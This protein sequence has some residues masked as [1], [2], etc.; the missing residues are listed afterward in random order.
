MVP[1]NSAHLSVSPFSLCLYTAIALVMVRC[2]CC[3][4]C[5]L[6]LSAR[7]YVCIYI[8]CMYMHACVVPRAYAAAAARSELDK[9]THSLSI[10]EHTSPLLDSMDYV[11]RKQERDLVNVYQQKKP[12]NVVVVACCLKYYANY[13]YIRSTSIIIDVICPQEGNMI[14]SYM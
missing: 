5:P 9:N 3:C 2:C 7:P 1:W 14:S 11:D 10:L 12:T 4:L 8:R 6:A 13:I